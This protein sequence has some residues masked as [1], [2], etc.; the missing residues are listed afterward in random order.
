M[1]RNI[2]LLFISICSLLL[3]TFTANGQSGTCTLEGTW[4]VEPEEN[5]LL[6]EFSAVSDKQKWSMT[7]S[8]VVTRSELTGFSNGTGISFF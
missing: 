2:Q 6:F 4:T 8:E 1:K 5:D 3:F 7:L